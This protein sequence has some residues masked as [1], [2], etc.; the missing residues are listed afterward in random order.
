MT[1][2]VDAE[3]HRQQM[4]GLE[5]R[6]GHLMEVSDITSH[7]LGVVLWDDTNLEEYVFPMIRKRTA[8][9]AVARNVG[10]FWMRIHASVII[11]S[12]PSDP[13]NM[14]SGLGPAPEPGLTIPGPPDPGAPDSPRLRPSSR[15]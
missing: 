10:R 9:P 6:E 14:R 1:R 4:V 2:R 3:L 15:S 8:I 11:P 7:T 5:A 12:V 13:I